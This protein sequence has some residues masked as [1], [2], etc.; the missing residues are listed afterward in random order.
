MGTTMFLLMT[1]HTEKR[2]LAH[3]KQK[4]DFLSLGC[5]KVHLTLVPEADHGADLG[6]TVF[7]YIWGLLHV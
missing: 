2:T 3:A 4:S 5:P 7:Y 6:F 1:L